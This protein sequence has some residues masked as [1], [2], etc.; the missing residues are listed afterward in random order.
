MPAEVEVR[1]T[2][3]ERDYGIVPCVDSE[4]ALLR[5]PYCQEV[6]SCGGTKLPL[7][8]TCQA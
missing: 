7:A 2:T 3:Q 1:A 5:Q 4:A 6:V 8:V